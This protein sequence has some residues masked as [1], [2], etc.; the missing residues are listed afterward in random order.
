MRFL[1]FALPSG[2]VLNSIWG[3]FYSLAPSVLSIFIYSIPQAGTSRLLGEGTSSSRALVPWAQ[4]ER[5]PEGWQSR[6]LAPS[7]AG[8]LS[9]QKLQPDGRAS[10]RQPRSSSEPRRN[11][12]CAAAG[13]SHALLS[14]RGKKAP[15][16]EHHPPAL[17]SCS[18]SAC[19]QEERAEL[20]T[21][22]SC[23]GKA[24]LHP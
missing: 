18:P 20:Y 13:I 1:S 10:S 3:V 23:C 2:L 24:E 8:G 16:N 9:Q 19:F 14:F 22:A 15:S 5:V 21:T 12:P 7:L 17:V 4:L 11:L 6:A